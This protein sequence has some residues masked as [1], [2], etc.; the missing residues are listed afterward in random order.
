MTNLESN[1]LAEAIEHLVVFGGVSVSPEVQAWL[2]GC[3]AARTTPAASEW[4]VPSLPYMRTILPA[5]DCQDLFR[6]TAIRDPKYRLHLDLALAKV[7]QIIA[8]SERWG[9]FEELAFGVLKPLSQRLL[10]LLEWVADH[11]GQPASALGDVHW[12]QF[13]AEICGDSAS[14]F[15][16]LDDQLWGHA[17]DAAGLF[18]LIEELYLP[19]AGHPVYFELFGL[20]AQVMSSLVHAARVDDGIEVSGDELAACEELRRLGAPILLKPGSRFCTLIGRVELS[21]VEHESPT[22]LPIKTAALG[23]PAIAKESTMHPATSEVSWLQVPQDKAPAGRVPFVSASLES[24]KWPENQP[25]GAPSWARLPESDALL[26]TTLLKKS[27]DHEDAVIAIDRHPLY[28]LLLQFLISEALDRELG[29]ETLLI[30]P[31]LDKVGPETE[32]GTS[33]LYR[34][35]SKVD[36]GKRSESVGYLSLGTLDSVMNR[37]ASELS[38]ESIPLP[39]SI[40]HY[41]LW[42]WGIHLLIDIKVVVGQRDRWALS[43]SLHDRLYT[44][45]LMGHVLRDRREVRQV[46]HRVLRGMW[47]EA[48]SAL[49]DASFGKE[50]S[51]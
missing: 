37:V 9:R 29:D 15:Q 27:S 43:S 12:Q 49:T 13:E 2:V 31:P 48:A 51:A 21:L 35:S 5:R 1:N 47:D 38:L 25:Q 50:V 24:G 18:P 30:A 26:E 11:A 33:V 3:G 17:R 32:W 34:P 28:G 39:Y 8:R 20:H 22:S 45:K 42:S 16:R 36:V 19:L 4:L 41:R 14:S 44:G 46:I 7:L 10:A 23:V 40:D 6:R